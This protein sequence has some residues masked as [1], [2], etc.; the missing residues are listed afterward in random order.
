[1]DLQFES[2]VAVLLAFSRI[3]PEIVTELQDDPSLRRRG[4]GASIRAPVVES[5][6]VVASGG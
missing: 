2:E 5:D 4:G 1:M 6:R 3:F